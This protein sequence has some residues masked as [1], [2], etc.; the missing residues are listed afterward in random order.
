MLLEL[1]LVMVR[2]MVYLVASERPRGTHWLIFERERKRMMRPTPTCTPCAGG[3]LTVLRNPERR[4]RRQSHRLLRTQCRMETQ[5][6]QGMMLSMPQRQVT[7]GRYGLAC[8]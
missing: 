7:K 6:L 4:R 8:I 1:E 3:S 5:L 2:S